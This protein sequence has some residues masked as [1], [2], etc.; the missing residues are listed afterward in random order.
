[1]SMI[2]LQVT[3]EVN[4]FDGRLEKPYAAEHNWDLWFYDQFIRTPLNDEY[5]RPEEYIKVVG[6]KDLTD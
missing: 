6:C 5:L 4:L 2:K 1:M 3:F